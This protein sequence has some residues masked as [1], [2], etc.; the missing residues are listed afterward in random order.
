LHDLTKTIADLSLTI[1][2]AHIGTFGE[3]AID[4]FYVTDL[5]G[6]KVTDEKRQVK[7]KTA[8]IATFEAKNGKK[9]TK[10]KP[11]ELSV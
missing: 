8:L 10:K 9:P 11:Q 4:V 5:T 1:G 2:S 6:M 7:I 3:R